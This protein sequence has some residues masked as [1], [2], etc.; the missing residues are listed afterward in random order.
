MRV[1][2]LWPNH[3]FKALSLNTITLATLEFWMGH[4]QAIA[5]PQSLSYLIEESD[6]PTRLF[7]E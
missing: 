4:I 5:E 1:E 2:T 6:V 7:C 3:L